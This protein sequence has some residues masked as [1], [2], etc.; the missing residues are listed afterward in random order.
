MLLWRL[1]NRA[2]EGRARAEARAESRNAAQVEQDAAKDD[3]VA[4]RLALGAEGEGDVLLCRNTQRN[5]V[6]DGANVQDASAGGRDA[7]GDSTY[8]AVKA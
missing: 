6:S 2:N 5:V 7:P 3:D 8:S 4:R 1:H